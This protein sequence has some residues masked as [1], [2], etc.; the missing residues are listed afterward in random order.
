MEVVEALQ[1]GTLSISPIQATPIAQQITPLP[2]NQTARDIKR[3]FVNPSKKKPTQPLPMTMPT[4][5]TQ[6]APLLSNAL[7]QTKIRRL[8]FDPVLIILVSVLIVLFGVL[9]VSLILR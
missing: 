5:Q 2:K 7:P 8:G 1:R 9:M 3:L 6:A 4:R